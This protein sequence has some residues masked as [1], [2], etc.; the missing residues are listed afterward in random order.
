MWNKK[1]AHY[2]VRS[3][4]FTAVNMKNAVFWYIKIP[5]VLNRRHITSLLQST[6]GEFFVRFVVFT[7]V[8]MKNVVFWDIETPFVLHRRHITSLLQS[9]AGLRFSRQWLWRMSS[10]GMLCRVALVI[11]EVSE[12]R[13]TTIIRV[14]RIVE[15]GT[16]LAAARN[17][18]TLRR[19]IIAESVGKFL[20]SV[21]SYKSHT[22]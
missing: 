4:V 18:R 1:Q 6:T 16:T 14:K 2:C 3:E 22:A 17:R 7:A 9:T 10:S 8:T 11:T 5:L 12:E 15:L 19:N 20:R 13:S 21:D